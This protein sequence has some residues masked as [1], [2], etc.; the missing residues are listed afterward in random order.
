MILKTEIFLTNDKGYPVLSRRHQLFVTEMMKFNIRFII[1]GRP[2]HEKGYHPYLQYIAFLKEKRPALTEASISE[3]PFR[4]C[5]QAPLQPL[6]DNLESQTY[7]VFEKDPIKYTQY[8][9]A[10]TEALRDT[11]PSKRTTIMVVGAGRGPLV[12]AALQA[13]KNANRKIKIY[14]VE[15]NKNAVTTLRN[16]VITE[17]WVD[18]EVI[19]SDMRQWKAPQE[20]DILVSEL[21][22]SWGDNEL[23]PECLDGAQKYLKKPGGLSIPSA[24]TSYV[25]PVSS[26]KLWHT[27]KGLGDP[28]MLETPFVVKLHNYHQISGE[29]ECFHFIHPNQSIDKRNPS[30]ADNSRFKKISFAIKNSCT[31]HGFA[32][33]FQANLY[34]GISISIAPS[35]FSEG[36]FSWFPLFIP[37]RVPIDLFPGDVL[38]GYF[39]RCNDDQKVWYEWAASNGKVTSPIHN[40]NGRSYWIGL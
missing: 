8:Q 34:K 18:V 26:H 40:P 36:M 38:D 23:S 35:S 17:K 29:K 33:F 37:V 2:K 12:K 7:E 9:S 31:L 13:A 39:W 28:K 19:P 16:L 30:V 11:P 5:I 27:I 14:A 32:G 25:A 3:A 22:G 24:Y 4:D 6:M 20:A 10:I 21:L 1:K 15:K